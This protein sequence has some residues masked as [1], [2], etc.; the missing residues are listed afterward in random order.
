MAGRRYKPGVRPVLL[1]GVERPALAAL[2][3]ERGL[4]V[5]AVALGA[6]AALVAEGEPRPL[7]PAVVEVRS[8]R[9]AG[10]LLDGG[11]DDVVLRSDP[12]GLVAARLAALIRRSPPGQL[13]F[14]DIA[15]DPVERQAT[16]AGLPLP[17]LPREYALLLYLTRQAPAL[18]D[19][20]TLHMV[21]WGRDFDP[22]TNVI[23]VHISRLRAKLAGGM[24]TVITE[25]GR[26]YR[27]AIAERPAAR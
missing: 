1:L 21:L 11:A 3:A 26:G 6:V 10:P 7:C 16:L 13:V 24:V 4:A 5:R 18:V 17:L 8:A 23:A 22:G 14:G 12:D 9:D 27:L 15:I 19:H 2:L 25:R 20:A